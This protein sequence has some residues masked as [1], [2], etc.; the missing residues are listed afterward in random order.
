MS[1]QKNYIVANEVKFYIDKG[2]GANE[3]VV[4]SDPMPFPSHDERTAINERLLAAESELDKA[5]RRWLDNR[6]ARRR[7]TAAIEELTEAVS[8]EMV[9]AM[10]Q[11]IESMN[12]F[13]RLLAQIQCET[14]GWCWPTGDLD[15]A[16][17]DA[18]DEETDE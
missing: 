3:E 12:R 5:T 1:K 6:E 17:D 2:D 18:L 13:A 15:E 8:V 16:V 14:P 10:E 4:L 9:A 7:L 11:A